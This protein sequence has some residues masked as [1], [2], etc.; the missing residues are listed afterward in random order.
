[1]DISNLSKQAL[2][3]LKNKK[4]YRSD[5]RSVFSMSDSFPEPIKTIAYEVNALGNTDIPDTIETLYGEI[6][7]KPK[8]IDQFIQN[9]LN[10]NDYHLVW[11]TATK[12]EADQYADS[13]NS[14]YEVNLPDDSMIV[15]DIGINGVLIASST[16]PL[17]KF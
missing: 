9:K 13:T 1:M 2:T 10:T 7:T 16:D 14:I 12:N 8:E 15:S 5:D 4:G 17:A 6:V 11:L 3:I